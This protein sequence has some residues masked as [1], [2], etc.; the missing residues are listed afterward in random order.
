MMFSPPVASRVTDAGD[1][2]SEADA[3]S[4]GGPTG[5]SNRETLYA[6]EADALEQISTTDTEYVPSD[7]TEIDCVSS[8]VDHNQDSALLADISMAPPSQRLR[9]PEISI[10]GCSP[11]TSTTEITFEEP[12]HPSKLVTRMLKL[13]PFDTVIE[14]TPVTP[15]DH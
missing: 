4:V 5:E 10:V 9:L 7:V 6:S 15:F 3:V 14:F 13:P 1:S 2:N 12:A 11:I 8:P